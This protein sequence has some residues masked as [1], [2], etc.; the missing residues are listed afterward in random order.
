MLRALVVMLAKQESYDALIEWGS[1]LHDRFALP[2]YLLQDLHK[3]FDDLQ[4][5][6]LG[7]DEPITR[8]LSTD[9]WRHVGNA[10]LACCRLNVDLAIE[11]WPLLGDTTEQTGGSRLV[12]AST[13][14]LQLTLRASGDQDTDLDGWRLLVGNYRCHCA[15]SR[16]IPVWY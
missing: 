13:K 12:D 16:T 6:G 2:F 10:E 15:G 9:N 3:V 7:L 8:R 14:R 1:S 5:A 11:F 4:C